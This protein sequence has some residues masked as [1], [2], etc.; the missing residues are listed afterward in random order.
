LQSTIAKI[1]NKNS[2][3]V[4]FQLNIRKTRASS[5]LAEEKVKREENKEKRRL[6]LLKVSTLTLQSLENSVR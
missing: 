6:K 1:L 2:K 5:L 3:M 4:K